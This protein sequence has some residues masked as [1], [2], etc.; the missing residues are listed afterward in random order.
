MIAPLKK[1]CAAHVLVTKQLEY[2]YEFVNN[3]CHTL[4]A[5]KQKIWHWCQIMQT[6][7]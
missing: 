3:A 6:R 1:N 2:F 4:S 5:Q 7:M